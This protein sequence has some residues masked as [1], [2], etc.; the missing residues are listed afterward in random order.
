MLDKVV[1]CTLSYLGPDMYYSKWEKYSKE[2]VPSTNES[3]YSIKEGYTN[4]FFYGMVEKPIFY[5]G[6]LNQ[7]ITKDAQAYLVVKDGNAGVFFRGTSHLL[8]ILSDINVNKTKISSNAAVHT[9]FYK[10]FMSIYEDMKKD[11]LRIKPVSVVFAGHSL[12][13]ALATIASTVF[14]MEGVCKNV[15]CFTI[16]SPRVG[17]REFCTLFK[18]HVLVSERITNNNDVV[19]M[20]PFLPGYEHVSSC[21]NIQDKRMEVQNDQQWWLFRAFMALRIVYKTLYN[22]SFNIYLKNISE[23]DKDERVD[24]STRGDNKVVEEQELHK[25]VVAD[26]L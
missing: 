18:T 23:I 3:F 13:G 19:P 8:D 11:L 15:S 26:T 14:A 7:S 17:N 2:V 16:G 21:L 9:G 1:G 10:Q 12:G 22:H 6:S 5:D 4:A 20:L 24:I 25:H